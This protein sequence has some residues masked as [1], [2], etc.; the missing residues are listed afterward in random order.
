MDS[1]KEGNPSSMIPGGYLSDTGKKGI[2][3]NEFSSKIFPFS[4]CF[5]FQSFRNLPLSK[6]EQ[7]SL[8]ERN[9]IPAQVEKQEKKKISPILLI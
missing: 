3:K 8:T 2:R 5:S 9:T 1:S 4:L 7:N 6:I